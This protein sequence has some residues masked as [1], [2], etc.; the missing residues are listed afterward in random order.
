MAK[1][2][3]SGYRDAV[4]QVPAAVRARAEAGAAAG[5]GQPLR[6]E[7]HRR[8][9]ARLAKLSAKQR[10]QLQLLATNNDAGKIAKLVDN[11]DWNPMELVDVVDTRSGVITYQLYLWPYGSGRLYA[12]D[13]TTAV[14]SI[15]QH[16][17]QATPGD[18]ALRTALAAAYARA[19]PKLR[20][21]VDFRLDWEPVAPAPNEADYLANRRKM[22]D[23]LD[24]SDEGIRQFADFTAK[25]RATIRDVVASMPENETGG[26]HFTQ[27]GIPNKVAMRRWAGLEPGGVFETPAGKWP[28]WK[29]LVAALHDQV[30]PA[31]AIAAITKVLDAMQVMALC[32]A[33]SIDDDY[34]L[35]ADHGGHRHGEIRASAHALR[36]LRLLGGL[37]DA[38]GDTAAVNLAKRTLAPADRPGEEIRAAIATWALVARARR[39]DE[40]FPR[41]Y[42]PLVERTDSIPNAQLHTTPAYRDIFER[43]ALPD[44]IAL[45]RALDHAFRT[46]SMDVRDRGKERKEEVLYGPWWYADLLPPEPTAKRMIDEIAAWPAG[47]RPRQPVVDVIAAVG[48][49]CVRHLDRA[50]AAKPRPAQHALLAAARTRFPAAAT[51]RS[52]GS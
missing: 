51:R 7:N 32:T 40:L 50:L 10:A 48:T 38:S 14:A 15:I 11:D 21:L 26:W 49:A 27:F 8:P 33:T 30:T 41:T 25:E 2:P 9:F 17:Y 44:R 23:L 36:T 4:D 43:L 22:V 16:T 28:V 35:F 42:L 31:A 6:F 34:A 46:R 20:E 18:L 13:S 12:H 29:W 24:G 39:R 45:D 37:L 1:K 3:S 47:P 19:K 52:S 5:R